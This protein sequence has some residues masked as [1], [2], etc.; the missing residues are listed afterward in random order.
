MSVLRR[1]KIGRIDSKVDFIN[2]LRANFSR[3]KFDAFLGELDLGNCTLIR[4]IL[5]YIFSL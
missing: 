3:T 2:I 4:Q 1:K 5:T